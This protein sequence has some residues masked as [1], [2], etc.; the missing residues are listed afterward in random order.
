MPLLAIHMQEGY[1]A[2]RVESVITGCELEIV[3]SIERGEDVII[4]ENAGW[5]PTLSRLMRHL[6]GPP[7]YLRFGKAH[8]S[9]MDA[10]GA[11][12]KVCREMGFD[13]S[14]FRVV[15]IETFHCVAC[16]VQNLVKAVPGCSIDLVDEATID[17]VIGWRMFPRLPNTRIVYQ[18]PGLSPMSLAPG[19]KLE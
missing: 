1:P 6:E 18:R 4:A 11:V 16:T 15:G 9:G 13:T 10:S 8:N 3:R 12:L 2:A 7:R 14:S 17:K 19:A 5:G